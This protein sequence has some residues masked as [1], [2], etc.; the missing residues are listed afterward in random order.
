MLTK[1]GYIYMLNEIRR[2]K[3]MLETLKDLENRWQVLSDSNC[4]YKTFWNIDKKI[5]SLYK[6]LQ[7]MKFSSYSIR[8]QDE[9]QGYIEHLELQCEEYDANCVEDDHE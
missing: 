3:G 5:E 6:K 4:F 8:A 1:Q 2:S 9:L 7:N